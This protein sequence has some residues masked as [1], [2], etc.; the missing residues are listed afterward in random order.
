MIET[1]V[2][3]YPQYSFK[4]CAVNTDSVFTVACSTDEAT[5]QA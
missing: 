3:L 5:S 2:L 1:I 4:S